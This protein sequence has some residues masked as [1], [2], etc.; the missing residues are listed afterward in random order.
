MQVRVFNPVAGVVSAQFIDVSN[1]QGNFDWAGAKANV[2]AAL[3]G[4]MFRLTEGLGGA[5]MVSPDPFA[6]HN[7]AAI[8]AEGLHRGAY[9][10]LH[11][12]LPGDKQAEYFVSEFSKLGLSGLDI[13]ACDSEKAGNSAT[14]VADC[15]GLFMETLR[16]L[17]PHSP[18]WV[19]SYLN[20]IQEG[21]LA[22]LGG[23]D[24]WLADTT[25]NAPRAP[26]PWQKW[27]GWQWGERHA[28]GQ[29]VDA[30]AFNGTVPDFNAYLASFAQPGK[31]GPYF[32]H[33]CDGSKTLQQIADSRNETIPTFLHSQASRWAS[34]DSADQAKV[35]GA[36][37][38]TTPD[39]GTI[40][41]TAGP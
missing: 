31:I 4:G 22:G 39:K 15:T 35:L 17:R 28:G 34:L 23:Y 14:Q 36:V 6:A 9:H 16:K 25:S 13:L 24:L 19:Y 5:G 37:A 12:D 30:D 10:F 33:V 40:Y 38:K 27:T 32:A 7:H 20:F 41:L 18:N 8:A 3:A 21:N 2:G 1:F 11:P 26:S 29:N